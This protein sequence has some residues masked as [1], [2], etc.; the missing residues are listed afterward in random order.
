VFFTFLN[1]LFL[2]NLWQYITM[3]RII[4]LMICFGYT[5]T[6]VGQDIEIGDVISIKQLI[7]MKSL[8]KDQMF[9]FSKAKLKNIMP[10]GETAK[11]SPGVYSVGNVLISLGYQKGDWGSDDL[12]KKKNAFDIVHRYNQTYSSHIEVVNQNKF[13]VTSRNAS[14]I[15]G[16]IFIGLNKSG[17][18]LLYGTLQYHPSEEANAQNILKDLLAGVEYRNP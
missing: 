6:C 9:A 1:I 12:S 4:F 7:G 2:G 18:T 15:Q 14:G 11:S 17:N 5:I 16:V 8:S 3:R 10:L 13:L